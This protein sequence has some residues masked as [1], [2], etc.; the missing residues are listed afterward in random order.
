MVVSHLCDPSVYFHVIPCPISLIFLGRFIDQTL[1]RILSKEFW[2][3]LQL[4][5]YLL[6]IYIMRKFRNAATNVQNPY[7]RTIHVE[8]T[9][10]VYKNDIESST[11]N[12][13]N[14]KLL[15]GKTAITV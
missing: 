11:K 5:F 9:L 12:Q 7:I 3:G 13:M 10:R 15:S 6:R 2:P 14:V 8:Y 1:F 4:Y